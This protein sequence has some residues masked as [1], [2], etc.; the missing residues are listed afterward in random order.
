MEESFSLYELNL[1]IKKSLNESFPL[2]YWVVAEISSVQVNRTGHCY[3]ELIE[4]E[5]VSN[6]LLTKARATIWANTYRMIRSYFESITG[7]RFEIGMK[8]MVKVTVQFHV[9]YGLSL[10]VIDIDPNYTVGD[11]AQKRRQILQQLEADG[12]INMNKELPLP[13]VVQRIAV[14]SSETAAGFGDFIHQL[15]HNS[16]GYYFD[17][18]LFAAAMQGEQTEQS[19]IAA[20]EQVYENMEQFDAVVIIRGGGSKTDL[21]YF[22]SY[23]LAFYLSQFPMPIITGI[24]HERDESVADIVAHTSLKTPTAVAGFLI[25]KASNFDAS[26]QKMKQQLS[27]LAQQKLG[28]E[29]QQLLMLKQSVIASVSAAF[30]IEKH[31]L[32]LH[33]QVF[34]S[35]AK[36]YI[37]SQKVKLQN[38]SVNPLK[39]AANQHISKEKQLLIQSKFHLKSFTKA[40][41]SKQTNVLALQKKT[42]EYLDPITILNRGFSILSQNGKIVKSIHDVKPD[43]PLKNQM[44]D[45]TIISIVPPVQT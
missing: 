43:L 37:N 33:R 10:N 35:R 14:I 8:I 24:G 27:R 44:K 16:S 21:S 22:D 32:S 23:D 36:E 17:Y 6:R 20:L 45:G 42:L 5:K 28:H 12:V 11:L 25:E 38:T 7:H 13:E 18:Q 9:L 29:K 39:V 19:V 41:V 2:A 15:D 34:I 26:L 40:F 30:E 31:R 4:N 3:L 1:Q